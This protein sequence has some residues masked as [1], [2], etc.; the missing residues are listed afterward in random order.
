ML[1][2]LPDPINMIPFG[3]AFGAGKGFVAG[4]KR[5]LAE[6]ALANAAVDA[7]VLP[8]LAGRGADVGIADFALDA[9][10]GAALGSMFGGAGGYLGARREARKRV[11]GKDRQ[12]ILNAF[13]LAADDLA[14]GRP[15]DVGQVPGIRESMGKAYD[16]VLDDPLGGPADEVLAVLRSPEFEQVLLERGAYAF[17]KDGALV[18]RGPRIKA[19]GFDA[20]GFGLVKIIWRHG[21]KNLDS[22]PDATR[23]RI[24]REDVMRL[25][26]ILEGF[27]P[28]TMTRGGKAA[29]WAVDGGNGTH[30]IA[31]V[32]KRK[33]GTAPTVI[34]MFRSDNIAHYPLS[35][36]REATASLGGPRPASD[37]GTLRLPQDTPAAVS[38][39]QHQG[40]GLSGESIGAD[41]AGV[42]LTPDFRVEPPEQFTPAPPLSEKTRSAFEDMGIDEKTGSS[43]EEIQA[44]ALAEGGLAPVEE[45]A[46]LRQ[47]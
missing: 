33:K 27:E 40:Q 41:A 14:N 37:A 47:A 11:H 45:T 5:G 36:K 20:A 1:G 2:S 24:T 21:E 15:V 13:E 39:H 19:Q 25:P 34:T 26:E 29:T 35:A 18:V 28:S 6:G 8:D 9:A 4:A 42:K 10:F 46:G 3:R 44:V 32:G 43:L 38:V 16:K 22:R 12:P 31:A 7:L 30:L 17:D 23:L